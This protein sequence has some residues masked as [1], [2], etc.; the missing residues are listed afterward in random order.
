VIALLLSALGLAGTLQVDILDVGQGDAILVRT[1]A[2]R[3]ILIDGGTGSVDIEHLLSGLGVS[4]LSMVIATHPHADHIGGLDEVI[5]A[6]PPKVFVDNGQTHTTAAYSTLMQTVEALGVNYVTAENGWS[7]ALDD[8]IVIEFLGPPSPNISGTRS[9]LNSNSVIT[10]ITH[11]EQC[12]LFTG[13]AEEPTE[14]LLR[15]RGIEPCNV[16]KVAH[17]GS[18]HS[19]SREW[20]WAIKPEIALISCGAR[21]RYGHPAEETLERLAGVGARVYR[22]DQHGTIHLESDGTSITVTA[23][24]EVEAVSVAPG[25]ILLPTND[26]EPRHYDPTPAP[27]TSGLLNLNKASESDLIELP[28]ISPRKA[29]SIVEYRLKY[30]AFTDIDQLD[31][32]PGIR[33]RAI[34]KFRDLVTFGEDREPPEA[35]VVAAQSGALIN[36]NKASKTELDALPGIGPAKA[37]AIIEYRM[38]YGAF[39]DIDQLDNVP[40]IGPATLSKIRTLVTL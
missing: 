11:G 25:P 23:E 30:G 6:M 1:P 27:D 21:N 37:S 28:R 22:T 15:R 31:N 39:T 2:G 9:D 35:V 36:L 17:H 10:R 33:P 19:T 40:G 20:L 7:R 24:T 4:S 32:V 5:T 8:D 12:F 29:T 18:A 26:V 38:K 3:N 16:L 14:A 13:D 34:R